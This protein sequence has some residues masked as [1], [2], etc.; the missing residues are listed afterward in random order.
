MNKIFLDSLGR[1]LKKKEALGHKFTGEHTK[2]YDLNVVSMFAE[3]LEKHQK[4]PKPRDP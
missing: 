3:K 2:A 1:C 4:V